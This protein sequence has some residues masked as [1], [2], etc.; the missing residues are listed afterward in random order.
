L[1]NR[2]AE[3]LHKYVKLRKLPLALESRVNEY[4][5]W[6]WKQRCGA[7]MKET[8]SYLGTRQW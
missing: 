8:M 7:T 1:A 2:K 5:E 6:S 4:I 3:T